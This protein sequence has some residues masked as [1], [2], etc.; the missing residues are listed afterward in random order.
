MK[1]HWENIYRTKKP[2]EV[3]WFESRP[4]ISLSLIGDTGVPKNTAIIDIGGGDSL[5]VDSLLEQGYS[6]LTVLDI[7]QQSLEKAKLRLG[8][9]AL[10][11]KWIESDIRDFKPTEK[12]GVWHDRAAFHFLTAEKD[13]QQYVETVGDALSVEGHLIIGTFSENGPGK[14]SELAIKQYSEVQLA[15]SFAGRFKK[16]RSFK[17]PHSTPSGAVQE[18]TFCRFR[19]KD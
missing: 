6:N 8:G 12:Y 18:F 3:S 10:L 7:S 1:E 2:D 13:V 16:V 4:E 11:V 15:A 9:K 19:L 5:L 17:Y 14:C